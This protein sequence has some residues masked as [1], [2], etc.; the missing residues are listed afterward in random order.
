[1]SKASGSVVTNAFSESMSGLIMFGGSVAAGGAAFLIWVA[2]VMGRKFD[3]LIE[4]GEIIGS[5]SEV[6]M[7]YV[8]LQDELIA[9]TTTIRATVAKNEWRKE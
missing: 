1:M 4:T 3:E 5:D 8:F 2:W 7:A 9:L 6:M